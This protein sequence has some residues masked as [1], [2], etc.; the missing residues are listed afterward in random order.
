MLRRCEIALLW[1]YH[2]SI[3]GCSGSS[4]ESVDLRR[5]CGDITGI[6][7]AKTDCSKFARPNSR[8]QKIGSVLPGCPETTIRAV[9]LRT[10][11]PV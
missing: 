7:G 2:E 9:S 10:H 4:I 1:M 8:D 11:S 6:C 5:D 3:E